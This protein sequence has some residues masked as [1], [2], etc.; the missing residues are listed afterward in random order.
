MRILRPCFRNLANGRG[1]VV[2][3]NGGGR[4]WSLGLQQFRTQVHLERRRVAAETV[5]G[6]EFRSGL[7]VR[8]WKRE[9]PGEHL[10]R[11]RV[12]GG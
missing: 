6:S 8:A 7:R 5:H 11:C 12:S 2:C 3:R 9:R 1:R 4:S 10:G